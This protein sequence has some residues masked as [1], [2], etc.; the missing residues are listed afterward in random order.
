MT[1][2]AASAR[3]FVLD[4]HADTVE[5][6]LRHGSA[7][8]R[9]R[10]DSPATDGT[11]LA[12]ALRIRLEAAGVWAR[13]PDILVGAVDAAG[14]SLSARPVADPPYVV[15]TSRGPMLRATLS[16]GRLVV[17][18]GTF[19]VERGDPN[20]YVRGPRSPGDAVRTTWR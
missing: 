6:V 1:D 10:D 8:L 19:A 9:K 7:V 5:A 11:A 3:E 4:A 20:R 18:F 14:Y 16:D 12:G 15:A 13:L 2:P 17:L